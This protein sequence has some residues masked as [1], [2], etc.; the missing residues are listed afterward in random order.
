MV[1]PAAVA[2]LA[3]FFP[4]SRPVSVVAAAAQHLSEIGVVQAMLTSFRATAG[5]ILV[6]AE[7]AR[8]PRGRRRIRPEFSGSI[9]ILS[10]EP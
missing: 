1:R 3:S 6:G 4:F 8:G 5:R 2:W 10:P 7:D 9:A